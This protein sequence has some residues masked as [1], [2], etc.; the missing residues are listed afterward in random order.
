MREVLSPCVCVCVFF[1]VERKKGME[2]QSRVDCGRGRE[3]GGGKRG[4]EVE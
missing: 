1:E 4:V 3:R 2:S